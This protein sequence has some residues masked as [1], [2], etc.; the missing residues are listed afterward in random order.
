MIEPVKEEDEE[1]HFD[2][3]A[4]L[5]RKRDSSPATPQ[6]AKRHLRDFSK[7]FARNLH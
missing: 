1:P 2:E 4:N 7:R 5:E 3:M 6:I